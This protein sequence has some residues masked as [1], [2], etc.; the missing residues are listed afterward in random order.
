M[1]S[2]RNLTDRLTPDQ[3]LVTDAASL[4]R[5]LL[6]APDQVDRDQLRSFLI[7]RLKQASTVQVDLPE[8]LNDLADWIERNASTVAGAYRAYLEQRRAGAGRR[9]FSNKAHALNFL[10]QVS[11][12]KLV[13]GA[14]LYGAL[15]HVGD[16]RYHHLIRT[17]LEEL[18]DGDPTLNHVVLYQQ[19]LADHDCAPTE[20]LEDALYVQGAIQLTLGCMGDEFLPELLGYNLGYEQLPLHLLITAF[21]L[22]ELRIDPYYFTLHVTVDNASSGHAHKAVE[23]VLNLM[24]KDASRAEF[25]ERVK[26]G[27]QLN[28]LGKGTQAVIADF[29][30]E[31]AVVAML[32]RKRT[33]GQYMHSDYCRLEGLTVNEWL[34]EPGRSKDFL[35]ALENRGWIKRNH[36]PEESRFWQLIAGP[37]AVMFGVFSGYEMQLLGDWIA[38]DWQSEETHDPFRAHFRRRT[39][40]TTVPTDS[41]GP[42]PGEHLISLLSPALHATPEGLKAT[43]LFS[44]QLVKGF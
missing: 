10:Q 7:E 13:D 17:Y 29:D 31:K 3:S 38:G 9:F 18:G 26:A 44:R 23:T 37:K 34:S 16:W 39:A 6:H 1:T 21:E 25:I 12:T 43:R 24:P 2:L 42:V 5:A 14:W 36:P 40:A 15:N 30:L 27:Y 19:L 32:E 4:Y 35:T 33:F 8:N 11:P 22:N 41:N 20:Q 28:E